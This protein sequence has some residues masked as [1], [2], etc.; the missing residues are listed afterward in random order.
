M[1]A[2]NILIQRLQGQKAF[3]EI[4]VMEVHIIWTV[5]RIEDL[6]REQ[7]GLLH[8]LTTNLRISTQHGVP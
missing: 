3:G 1:G 4:E 5:N 7:D 6:Q 2:R 8:L